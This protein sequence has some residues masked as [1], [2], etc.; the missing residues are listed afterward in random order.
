MKSHYQVLGVERSA[1]AGEIKKAY[2][3]RVLEQHPDKHPGD[4]AIEERFKLTNLAYEVLGDP[5]KKAMYDMGF[6]TGGKF[7]PT[8]IDPSLLDY[9]TFFK[10][11]TGLFGQ[12]LDEV[13]PGGFK[14]RVQ[15]AAAQ[16][17]GA[18]REKKKPAQ[19]KKRE[20]RSSAPACGVC[21]D[22]QRI[23]LQQ[24]S[25]TVFVTCRACESRKAG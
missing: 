15:R 6:S 24:G 4:K 17:D 2:R 8:N 7:D 10:T 25:F 22:T 5:K 21:N 1:D 23:S 12:Y 11:F 16:A 9:D 13:I 3:K 19:K 20:K 14:N 18:A